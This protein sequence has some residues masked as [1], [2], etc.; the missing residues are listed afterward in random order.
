VLSCVCASI[1][2]TSFP[3]EPS[4]LSCDILEQY[5]DGSYPLPLGRAMAQTV[6]GFL[7]QTPVFNTSLV[8]VGILVEK[9]ALGHV[10]FSSR[11]LSCS[12]SLSFH[13][14]PY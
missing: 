3:P 11:Y 6:T 13:C 1:G 4:S 2:D 5:R 9:L 12:L 7:L 14:A 10:L 8:F